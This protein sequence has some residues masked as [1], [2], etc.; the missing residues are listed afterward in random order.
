MEKDNL[1]EQQS[2]EAIRTNRLH[3]VLKKALDCSIGNK[4]KL[5]MKPVEG[6]DGEAMLSLD[7]DTLAADGYKAL[8]SAREDVEVL[9]NSIFE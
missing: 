8:Q 6:M 7:W 9:K 4:K 5:K 3:A 1:E 2:E